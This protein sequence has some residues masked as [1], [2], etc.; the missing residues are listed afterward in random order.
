MSGM[1]M[2]ADAS[3]T[4]FLVTWIWLCEIRQRQADDTGRSAGKTMT[5]KRS[6][7]ELLANWPIVLNGGRQMQALKQVRISQVDCI[8][9]F[10]HFHA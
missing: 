1:L 6:P 3:Q 10:M 9:V 5:T 7:V 8:A 4:A 2:S